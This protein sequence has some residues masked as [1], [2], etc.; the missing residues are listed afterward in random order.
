[1][2]SIHLNGKNPS[3]IGPSVDGAGD[4][5]SDTTQAGAQKAPTDAAVVE[6]LAAMGLTPSGKVD[7]SDVTNRFD[8]TRAIT[9]QP[10][11]LPQDRA[12]VTPQT[13]ALYQSMSQDVSAALAMAQP[14]AVS[15]GAAE[16][17]EDDAQAP[18]NTMMRQLAQVSEAEAQTPAGQQRIGAIVNDGI[19]A[20]ATELGNMSGSAMM[21]A[22]MVLQ[23]QNKASGKELTG[24]LLDM[25][26]EGR[27]ASLDEQI[28]A[29]MDAS[30]KVKEAAEKQKKLAFLGPL[31]EAIM[32]VV[33]VIIT[34]MTAGSATA[35]AAMAIGA[36]IGFMA[37]GAA[38]GAKK[39]TGFDITSAISGLALGASVAGLA[40][41]AILFA[42][43]KLATFMATRGLAAAA[44]NTLAA[45][46][47]KYGGQVLASNMPSM[48]IIAAGAVAQ[49]VA[50]VV[51]AGLNYDY[52]KKTADAK[53]VQARAKM[54]KVMSEMLQNQYEALSG[55][56]QG[57]LQNHNTAVN[58]ALAMLK[59]QFGAMQ[60]TISQL[61]G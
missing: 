55:S 8:A 59:T 40:S 49:G 12:P 37:G 57:M 51:K 61:G 48:G 19:I 58:Q 7:R 13:Q 25:T 33:A 56:L 35:L 2:S 5:S 54:E 1:M 34:V 9:S 16:S 23:V 14:P 28:K 60:K 43:E 21:A 15:V 29:N 17:T 42:I 24:V 30:A 31:I 36:V 46:A 27:K 4:G 32:A 6:A 10:P 38:G 11:P 45:Q 47:S 41:K 18:G 22:F 53:E 26:A 39:G 44:S 50:P 3:L 20:G 52:E